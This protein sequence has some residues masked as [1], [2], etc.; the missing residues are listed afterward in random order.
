MKEQRFHWAGPDEMK[1]QRFHWAGPDE[2]KEQRFHWAY[3][4]R[5]KCGLTCDLKGMKK[6]T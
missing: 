6:N 3:A 4:R 2:I 5:R 1:E